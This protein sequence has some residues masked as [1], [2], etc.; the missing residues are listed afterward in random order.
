L[1]EIVNFKSFEIVKNENA[2]YWL[3]SIDKKPIKRL[4]EA[5]PELPL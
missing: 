1:Q 4:G 5:K 3:D 2:D